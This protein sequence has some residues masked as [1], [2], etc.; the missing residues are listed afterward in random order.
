MKKCSNLIL[1][2]IQI[3]LIYVHVYNA[4]SAHNYLARDVGLVCGIL[5]HININYN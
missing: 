2:G 1:I 5:A 3:I 4:P